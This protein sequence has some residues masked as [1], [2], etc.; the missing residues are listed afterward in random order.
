M[1]NPH[2]LH[3]ISVKL[4]NRTAIGRNGMVLA[5]AYDGDK[6][7]SEHRIK[8]HKACIR[9]CKYSFE[10]GGHSEEAHTHPQKE[11]KEF[12]LSLIAYP[13]DRNVP[14]FRGTLIPDLKDAYNKKDGNEWLTIKT[15]INDC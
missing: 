12:E 7:I 5:M 3:S 15:R 9:A 4:Y 8:G 6:Q 1:E 11:K 13:G 14:D 2:L 10:F